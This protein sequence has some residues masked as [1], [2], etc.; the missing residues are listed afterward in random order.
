MKSQEKALIQKSE[1]FEG[2]LTLKTIAEWMYAELREGNEH[3]K[4][5]NKNQKDGNQQQAEKVISD[6]SISGVAV[7]SR[8][9]SENELFF[10]LSGERVDGH[11]FLEEAVKRRAAAVVVS[12]AVECSLPQLYVKDTRIALGQ[13]ANRYRQQFTLPVVSITGSYGK[14][15]VKDMLASI[16]SCEGSVLATKGNLNTDIGVPLTLMQL[17]PEHRFAVIEMGA[18]KKGDIKYLMEIAEPQFALITN[19]GIAHVEIFGSE[20]EVRLAKGEMFANLKPD[21]IV[22]MHDNDPNLEYWKSLLKGQKIFYFGSSS[23]SSLI[24]SAEHYYPEYSTVKLQYKNETI[25]VTIFAAGEH[26]LRNAVA[27]AALAL[28]M[29]A[30]LRAV[31]H[32]LE[33]FQPATGRL[34]FKKGLLNVVII[35]DTYNANPVSMRAALS[36][37]AAQPGEKIFVMGDMLEL[38][39]F[40]KTWHQ[41]I[42]IEAKRLG[43]Q[44]VFGFGELTAEATIAFGKEAK[45]YQ[46]KKALIQ[47][48]LQY[49]EEL[50]K[51]NWDNSDQHPNKNFKV[52]HDKNLNINHD[53]NLN[54]N[55]DK[56]LNMDHDKNNNVTVLVKGSRGMRMEEV[57]SALQSKD[58]TIGKRSC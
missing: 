21:G 50:Y 6:I 47:D 38:G 44:K 58:S 35:D 5:G 48:L 57:V 31:K 45:Q 49:I 55:H 36:V 37:L 30:S 19:A 29:G 12:Q 18:R 7:D 17:K 46:D 52:N 20:E 34:E 25:G 26:N 16:L 11:Q 33:L 10:A 43:V 53:K 3:H 14:T 24:Q 40:A 32:G 15:T 4:K 54:I 28:A 22:V 2:K 27:A 41:D 23:Q 51:K 1:A 13:L 39:S 9:I 8:S 56:N 42:G